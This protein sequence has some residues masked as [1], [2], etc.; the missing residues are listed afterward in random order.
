MQLFVSGNHIDVGESLR[1]H[2]AAAL[3]PVVDRHFG[4]AIEGK[5]MFSR[6]RHLFRAD[7]HVHVARG[8]NVQSHA[9]A[10]DPYAA[11]DAA[12]D[13]LDT[14]LERYKGR[15]VD[16]HQAR[17]AGEAAPD[18]EAVEAAAHYVIDADGLAGGEAIEDPSNGKPPVIAELSTN[19]AALTVAEAVTRMDLSDQPVLL[20][21]NRAH[22][23]LNVVYR[24]NDG[25]IGWIDPGAPAA[26]RG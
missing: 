22:G 4:R 10:S 15:L 11:F 17:A 1:S 19:V 12:T 2:V 3:P 18:G 21:R 5:V 25:T 7:I 20:F 16:R 24:R 8:V 13:R 23:G 6:A 14:R 26:G 9:E